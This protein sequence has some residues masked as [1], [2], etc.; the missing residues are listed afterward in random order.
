MSDAPSILICDDEA[1]LAAELGEY[2]SANGW[3]AMV[4]TSAPDALAV[5]EGGV[6]PTCLLTDLRIAEYDGAELVTAAR[7]L[8][9]ALQP[10]IFVM[11][12]G[13]VV[14]ASEAADFGVDLLYLK[15]IDPDA[16]LGDICAA[17]S[18]RN[19]GKVEG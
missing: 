7:S 3:I 19:A 15:P 9:P 6:T 18:R 5:L 1:D 14:D 2:M 8:P 16:I 4:A 11:M 10:Q 12:T 17:L 13:H